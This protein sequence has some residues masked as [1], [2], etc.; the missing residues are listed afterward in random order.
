MQQW[1]GIADLWFRKD[2]RFKKPKAIVGCK[3]YTN[4]LGF[5]TSPQAAVFAEVWKRVLQEYLRE[6]T[7]MADCAKL[8]FKVAVIRDNIDLQWS[9]FNDS[10]LN[11]VSETLQKINAL[12][13]VECR[14]IFNQVKE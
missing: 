5:S 10:L 6:F 4:D 3:I 14:E 2:D 8:D 12:K 9:G 7:Y 1:D 11:F 13:G